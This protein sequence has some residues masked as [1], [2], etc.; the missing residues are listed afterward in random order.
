MWILLEYLFAQRWVLKYFSI[1][2]L[3]LTSKHSRFLDDKS[4]ICGACGRRYKMMCY[5]TWHVKWFHITP[6]CYKCEICDQSFPKE[7]L[8]NKHTRVVHEGP[9]QCNQCSERFTSKR[10]LQKH[11]DSVHLVNVCFECQITFP[12]SSALQK[13]LNSLKK[14]KYCGVPFCVKLNL[15]SHLQSIHP[16]KELFQCHKCDTYY[17]KKSTLKNHV[18]AKHEEQQLYHCEEWPI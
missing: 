8:L 5:L 3:S 4:L 17:F 14:C 12:S 2:L 15:I 6:M 1:W 10:R 13:H 11:V 7:N 18:R 9:H 16:E